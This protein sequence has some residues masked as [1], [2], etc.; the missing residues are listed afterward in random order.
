[1][2]LPVELGIGGGVSDDLLVEVL[3]SSLALS[4]G[5]DCS[6]HIRDERVEVLLVLSGDFIVSSLVCL[7]PGDNFCLIKTE[8]ER[9]VLNVDPRIRVLN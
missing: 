9:V 5:L 8:G 7:E 6:V 3:D 2:H 1:M 4:V